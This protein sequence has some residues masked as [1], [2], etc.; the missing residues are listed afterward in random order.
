MCIIVTHKV[1]EFSEVYK[2]CYKHQ[3]LH[4][5]YI[6]IIIITNYKMPLEPISNFMANQKCPSCG[7]PLRWGVTTKVDEKTN[8]EICKICKAVL[9]KKE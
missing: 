9:G 4:N 7:S 8:S 6:F 5:L 2:D 1:R 3:D